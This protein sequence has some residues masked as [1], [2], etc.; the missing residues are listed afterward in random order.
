MVSG[1]ALLRRRLQAFVR[2]HHSVLLTEPVGDV[3]QIG[4]E[5]LLYLLP[6]LT[7]N[8]TVECFGNTP[9]DT[10][11]GIT[12]TPK[13]DGVSYGILIGVRIDEGDDGLWNRPLARDIE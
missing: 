5:V 10:G 8:T 3:P 6:D 1:A 4:G 13:G 7:W 11:K 12:I 2:L 9:R